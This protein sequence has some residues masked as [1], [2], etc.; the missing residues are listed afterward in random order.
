MGTF[1][2]LDSLQTASVWL[3]G[4]GGVL[5]P[6]QC[7]IVGYLKLLNSMCQTRLT[8]SSQSR[9]K[10]MMGVG[11]IYGTLFTKWFC[12][13]DAPSHVPHLKSLAFRANLSTTR[14]NQNILTFIKICI[15]IDC[16]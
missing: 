14:D 13:P 4:G 11:S 2:I 5:N 12:Q 6:K 16:D 15:I 10:V 8:A 9:S 1:K 3:G 7:H